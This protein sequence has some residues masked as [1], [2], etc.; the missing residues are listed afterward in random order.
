M[1]DENVKDNNLK[2]LS[3]D[4]LFSLSGSEHQYGT[5]TK[6]SC[7]IIKDIQTSYKYK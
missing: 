6:P 7:S 4:E 3:D 5:Y 1:K 2:G